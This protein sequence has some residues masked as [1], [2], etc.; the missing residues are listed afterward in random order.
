M[1]V[2]LLSNVKQVEPCT[3]SD[4]LDISPRQLRSARTPSKRTAG[5]CGYQPP[6]VALSAVSGAISITPGAESSKAALCNCRALQSNRMCAR[7]IPALAL[8]L[9]VLSA[10]QQPVYPR[11]LRDLT[12]EQRIEFAIDPAKCRR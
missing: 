3:G 2:V 10:A 7:A 6:M 9:M 5:A 11:G 12:L 8:G 4:I 1:T